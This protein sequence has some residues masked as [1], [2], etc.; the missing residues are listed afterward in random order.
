M[1]DPI[2]LLLA[3][4]IVLVTGAY[5]YQFRSLARPILAM[6]GLL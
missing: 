3:A 1:K 2:P 4:W 5:L 6:F